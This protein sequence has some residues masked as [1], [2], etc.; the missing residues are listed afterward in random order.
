MPCSLGHVP[1][2][3]DALLAVGYR[4]KNRAHPFEKTMFRHEAKTRQWACFHI[5]HA[6]TIVHADNDPL[7]TDECHARSPPRI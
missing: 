7:F 1:Q 6:E 4:R 2:Q 3:I 5:V